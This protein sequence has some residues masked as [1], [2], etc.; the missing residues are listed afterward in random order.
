MSTITENRRDLIERIRQLEP[1]LRARGVQRLAVFGSFAR[2]THRADS[3]VDLLV[4]FVSG[5]KTFD[6][7][8]AVCELL[9]AQLQRRVEL[10]TPE[11]LSPHIGPHILREAEDVVAAN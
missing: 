3:D 2:D 8:L 11:S 5:Q 7:F 4:E 10:L 1:Q 6:N 9:E